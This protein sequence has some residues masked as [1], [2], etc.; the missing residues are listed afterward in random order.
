MC[1]TD[2]VSK[3]N[4]EINPIG[5]APLP[6]SVSTLIVDADNNKLEGATIS[7]VENVYNHNTSQA[8]GMVY[9]SEVNPWENIQINYVGAVKRFKATEVPTIVVL[10]SNMMDEVI[11]NAPKQKSNFLAK[12]VIGLCLAGVVYTVS[13]AMKEEPLKV[14]L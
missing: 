5:F 13:Q 8:D 2:Q 9:L 3:Y 14:S 7:V 12:T 11:V 1:P 4:K 10:G 6:I